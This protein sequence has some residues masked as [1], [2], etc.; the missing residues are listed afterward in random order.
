MHLAR[1]II[2]TKSLYF[3]YK[4]NLKHWRTD[5]NGQSLYLLAQIKSPCSVYSTL[6]NRQHNNFEFSLDFFSKIV[7]I[8]L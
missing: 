5:T 4:Y 3:A 6:E 2:K 1:F 7:K 8:A